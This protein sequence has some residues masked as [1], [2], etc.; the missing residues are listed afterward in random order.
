MKLNSSPATSI[1]L[2]RLGDAEIAARI[3]AGDADAFRALMQRY[4]RKLYRAARS[5]VGNDAETEDVVQEAWTRA[6]AHIADYRG[7]SSLATWLVRIAL[8]EAL[9]RKRR[10]RPMVELNETTEKET[11]SVVSF[12][13]RTADPE[14]ALSRAQV[15]RRLE[16]AIDTLPPDF[17]TVFILREIEDMSGADVARQLSIPEATAKTRLHRARALLR[18]ELAKDFGAVLSEVFPFDGA[19]CNRMIEQVLRRIGRV[20]ALQ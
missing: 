16:Q 18:K 2:S 5:V 4:N 1:D 20:D 15:R 6:F 10:E 8:N 17:R 19:R 9:G 12:P 14:S 3:V 13:Q 7:E 11:S